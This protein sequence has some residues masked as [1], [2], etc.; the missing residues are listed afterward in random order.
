MRT[1]CCPK[2]SNG[3]LADAVGKRMGLPLP[4]P[5]K[6]GTMSENISRRDLLK[7]G[8]VIG[9]SAA[10]AGL[11][12]CAAGAESPSSAS[13]SAAGAS[14]S[15]AAGEA[16]ASAASEGAASTTTG[17]TKA[18]GHVR[19]GLPSWLEA[20]APIT[21]ITEEKDYDI[22]V[23]GAGAPGCPAALIAAENGAKVA[24]VQ[25]Q[26]RANAYG[27]TGSGVDLKNSDPAQVAALFNLCMKQNQHRS[28]T[29]LMKMWFDYGGEAVAYV[30]EKAAEGG[31]QVIDQG[32]QQHAATQ[33][34]NG[35]D[36]ITMVTSFFGPK[37]Y[38]TGNG[39]QDMCSVLEAAG[40]EIFYETPAQQL[41]VSDSGAVTGVIASSKEGNIQFNASK[42]VIMAT[43]DYQCDTDMLAYYLP[44]M[45]DLEPKQDNR[46]GDGHKM[47]I[48]AGGC[49]ENLGH[50]KMLHDFDAGPASMCDMPFL[51]TKMNGERFVNETVEMSVMNCYLNNAEDNGEYVQVFDNDYME[52][53]A[54]F[55]GKLVSPEDIRVYMPEEE[56]FESPRQGVLEAFIATFKADT[57]EE[58]AEKLEIRDAD[59]FVASVEKWNENCKAGSDPDFGLP[60]NFLKSIDTPPYW[61][62]HRHVR[63]SAF[64]SGV[65]IDKDLQCLTPEGEKIEGLYAIGNCSGGF[66][67]GIDYPLDVPG[68]NL[69]RNYTQGYCLGRA[70]ATGKSIWDFEPVK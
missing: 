18:A 49:M 68:M 11:A 35:W 58:L 65:K 27:N 54:D 51:R 57:L 38:N 59:A 62:I 8:G 44:D 43:G 33:G 50:T 39:M 48:W 1:Y 42:G 22:V 64:C 28:N 56:G 36:K 53:A 40:V 12:G 20:P 7:F 29:D 63:F 67:G 55:P 45:V 21:D 3:V 10:V 69:G 17:T 19:E 5:H 24:V 9:A 32:N 4:Q 30:I 26:A 14:A 70:L 37:P 52:K 16:S 34:K 25:K 47:V 46:T 31:A 41:V 15:S 60:A 2:C 6:E 61:G 13:A 66:Y 23:I